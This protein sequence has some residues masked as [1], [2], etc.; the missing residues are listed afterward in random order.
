M[1]GIKLGYVFYNPNPLGKLTSGDCTVRAITKAMS[2]IDQ[3]WNWDKAYAALCSYGAKYCEMPSANSVWG[4]FLLDHGFEYHTLMDKCR[5]CYSITDFL[6][7]H[8]V[9]TYV[10]GT[11]NHACCCF[12][13]SLYDTFNSSD[14]RPTYYFELKEERKEGNN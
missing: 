8:Q 14:L 7:E 10:I 4:A 3:S 11:D 1:E 5:T 13:G 9:G 12:M 6:N 2:T